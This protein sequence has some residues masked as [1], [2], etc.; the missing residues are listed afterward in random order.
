MLP[1]NKPVSSALPGKDALSE[2]GRSQGRKHAARLIVVVLALFALGLAWRFTPLQDYL[3]PARLESL[4][5]GLDSEWARAA[6]AITGVALLS[7][8]MVPLGVL[9]LVAG[10]IFGSWQSFIYVM[11]GAMISAAPGFMIGERLGKSAL[12]RLDSSSAL[13]GLSRR[14]A[15]RGVMAVALLRMVPVAP[16][17][18]F[19]LIAGASHVSFRHYML[20]TLLGLLPGIGTLTLFSG[21]LWQAITQ[22]DTGNVVIALLAAIVLVGFAL[23][24][25]RWLK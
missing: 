6:A 4:V 2:A 8:L 13:H 1:D 11:C 15:E 17:T 9:A 24:T 20:G 19:N 22:P 21:S 23:A 25:R 10:A 3:S 18:V 16:Y 14:V 7:L 5:N 12:E